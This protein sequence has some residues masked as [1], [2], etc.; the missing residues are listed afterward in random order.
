M[1]AIIQRVSG[2]SLITGDQSPRTIARGIVALI[3]IEK[4][5]SE[6]EVKHMTERLSS[7][8]FSPMPG[9]V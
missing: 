7:T 5:D 1:R 6:A 4:G 9:G 3:G 2:A 8:E